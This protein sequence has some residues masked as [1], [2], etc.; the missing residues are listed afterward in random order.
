MKQTNKK[1]KCRVFWICGKPL[2]S[3]SFGWSYDHTAGLWRHRLH[4]AL[5][6]RPCILH[7]ALESDSALLINVRASV[8]KRMHIRV[9]SNNCVCN[10]AFVFCCCGLGRENKPPF[11]QVSK[12]FSPSVI[13]HRSHSVL[14][15][16]SSWMASIVPAGGAV[17][18]RDLYGLCG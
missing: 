13:C 15:S 12:G 11:S 1:I 9:M 5:V 17:R 7:E 2:R 10:W 18:M 6:V 4:V 14:T 8:H 16:A 3:Y